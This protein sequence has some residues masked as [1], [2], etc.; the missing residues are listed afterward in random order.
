MIEQAWTMPRSWIALG[1]T[2]FS[3]AHAIDPRP[4]EARRGFVTLG[5]ANNP[6]KFTRESLRA[7]ARITAAVPD[8][9]FCF[10][11][12]EGASAVFRA[13]MVAAFAA[14]GV[15]AERIEFRAVRGAHM[16]GYNDIDVTLDTFP[17]TGGT[18]TV[19]ALWMGAPV[20]SL[21]GEGFHERL[22][23]SILTNAGLADLIADDLEAY[24]AKALA[25]AADRA[26]RA[27]LR[28]TLRERLRAGP[29]GDAAGF[30]ADFYDLMV[31]MASRPG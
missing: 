21:R 2:T 15:G 10:L 18:T 16:G 1:P 5:T 28:A 14:E 4:P 11:R 7:W 23:A 29:L 20:V 13:N 22:S 31:R 17:L 27:E 3:E 8:A 19:E 24:R 12:P 26:R 6:Y 9:R 25:L 30:A